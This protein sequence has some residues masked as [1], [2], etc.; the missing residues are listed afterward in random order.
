MKKFGFELK[1]TKTNS[2]QDHGLK[3]IKRLIAIEN[4]NEELY[5]KVTNY[6]KGAYDA[7]Q[8]LKKE[9]LKKENRELENMQPFPANN[10]TVLTSIF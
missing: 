4:T 10:R 8:T 9:N 7:V 6:I 3:N 1:R 2:N 5:E